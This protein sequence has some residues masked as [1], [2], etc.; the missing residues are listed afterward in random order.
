[1]APREGR[2]GGWG[3]GEWERGAKL[4]KKE[5]GLQLSQERTHAAQPTVLSRKHW[6]EAKEWDKQN[7]RGQP[8]RKHPRPAT[9]Q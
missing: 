3:G 2:G 9:P 8:S 4:G 7:I 1:M 6:P 5:A